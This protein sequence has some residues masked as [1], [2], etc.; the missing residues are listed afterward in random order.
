MHTCK[1]SL[2]SI[3]IK[4]KQNK[5]KNK[6]TLAVL[7]FYSL[8]LSRCGFMS[9]QLPSGPVTGPGDVFYIIAT[10]QGGRLLRANLLMLVARNS[11]PWFCHCPTVA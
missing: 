1:F 7:I 5:A 4:I 6:K 10:W 3:Q 2:Y 9:K 8:F 11:M